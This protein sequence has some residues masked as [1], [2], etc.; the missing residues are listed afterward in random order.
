MGM[1]RSG[2]M[3]FLAISS[4]T[5]T[6][7]WGACYDYTCKHGLLPEKMYVDKGDRCAYNTQK[8]KRYPPPDGA[9]CFVKYMM[10][11]C[12]RIQFNC[13]SLHLRNKN[14]KCTDPDKM[15]IYKHEDKYPP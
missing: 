1:I 14:H 10:G 8:G 7:V 4:I 5:I 12:K 6:Q 2:I 15:I 3:L 13:E 9:N 11:T